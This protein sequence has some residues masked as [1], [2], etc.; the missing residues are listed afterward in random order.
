VSPGPD[1]SGAAVVEFVLVGVLLIALFLGV[2]QIGL[3]LH[4]R[5]TLVAS[6]AEG[7]RYAANADRLPHDGAQYASELI[8]RSLSAGFAHDVS[9]G[10][11]AASGTIEIEVRASLPVIGF[12]GPSRALVVRGHALEELP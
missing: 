3:A 12:F 11:D 1:E 9:A 5:N 4:V 8:R 10:Y 2:L 7:A 6:A